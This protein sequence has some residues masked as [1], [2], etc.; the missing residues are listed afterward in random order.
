MEQ[1]ADAA[2]RTGGA[3]GRVRARY[4]ARGLSAGVA[5]RAY[6]L[7]LRT[8]LGCSAQTPQHNQAIP[9]TRGDSSGASIASSL[10]AIWRAY[11][12]LY[13]K[14]LGLPFAGH[15]LPLAYLHNGPELLACY[16]SIELILARSSA[17]RARTTDPA[18]A[19]PDSARCHSLR[20]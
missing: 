7:V 4:R 14:S 6:P 3:D 17:W 20:Q 11:V 18:T 9:G 13:E 8:H 16:S 2:G 12:S 19:Q 5:A 10:A 1:R 15:S